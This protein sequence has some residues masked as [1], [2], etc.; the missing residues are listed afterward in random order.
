MDIEFPSLVER[1]GCILTSLKSGCCFRGYGPFLPRNAMQARPMSSCGVR[2]SVCLSRSIMYSVEKNKYI[3]KL[4]SPSSS[5]AILLFP[6]QTSWQYSDG[7]PSDG[8]VE[9]RWGMQKSRFWFSIWLH[10]V[11][12]TLRLPAVINTA[13]P[14]HGK[15]WHLPLVVSGGVCWW[16]ETTTKCSWQ[17]V[18][19]LRRRQ[20]NNI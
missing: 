19:T 11:L 3:F 17:E 5:H 20:P 15:L 6:Y 9:C 10:C 16:R 14:D 1:G 18:S 8:G 7:N 12:S 4:F 13:P 2:L